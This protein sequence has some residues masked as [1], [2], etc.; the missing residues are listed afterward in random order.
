MNLLTEHPPLHP[1]RNPER[2]AAALERL[3]TGDWTRL[4]GAPE[5]EAALRDF[6]GG[7]DI[8]YVASGTA[9]LE[10]ILLGHNIGP[11]DEVITTPYTWGAT[12]A[13]ILAIGAIPVFADIS[14]ERPLID[15]DSVA[16]R[17]TSRTKAILAVHLFGYPCDMAALRALA[18]E[19][20]L[21]LFE[22]GSQA[23]GARLNGERV[24]R[25]G[26]AAAFSCMALKP[27]GG[28]EGGYCIFEDPEAAERAYLY[29]K[30][31]RG[32]APDR[33]EALHDAGLLDSLQL[34]WRPCAIGAE[35]V[36]AGLSTLDEENEGRRRNADHL[37]H[38]LKDLP[39]LSLDHPLPGS[40]PVHHLMSFRIDPEVLA[41]SP[42]DC[43][44]VL[45]KT[46]LGAFHYIPTPIHQLRRMRWREYDG[47]P[48]FWHR[49]LET[50]GIE[51]V[52]GSCPQ[53]EARASSSFEIAW[54]WTVEH[55]IAMEQILN[56]LQTLP[57]P[58]D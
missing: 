8:W 16:G 57:T 26:H 42:A 41:L 36:R 44:Q 39:G 30:H 31:P 51:Y 43:V 56:C 55:P 22:D 37:R 11:G 34:G 10:A 28:T 15:P 58:S 27:L 14:A 6:H 19:H 3:K 2:L 20:G 21:F 47:P 12:V 4:E 45:G 46:G 18:D 1:S 50:H 48:V 23:H 25:F 54:N 7:G 32:L 9:A 35:L 24:G 5:T 13:A 29:G 53:A 40:E 38:L 33:A 52:D 17:I 49:Q